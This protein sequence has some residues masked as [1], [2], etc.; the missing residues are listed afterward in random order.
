MPATIPAILDFSDLREGTGVAEDSDMEDN[1]LAAWIGEDDGDSNGN[2]KVDVA[3][4]CGLLKA[5]K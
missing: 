4:T 2:E 5:I 3:A 1:V